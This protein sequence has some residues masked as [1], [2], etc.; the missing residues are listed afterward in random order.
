MSERT[1]RQ[2][3]EAATTHVAAAALHKAAAISAMRAEDDNSC[4]HAMETNR[5]AHRATLL[6][7]ELEDASGDTPGADNAMPASGASEEAIRFHDKHNHYLASTHHRAAAD[8]HTEAAKAWA[9]EWWNG[10]A[11]VNCDVCGRDVAETQL[12]TD[13]HD[14]VVCP[15]CHTTGMHAE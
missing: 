3:Q 6:A 2:R 7:L 14:N 5:V 8:Y 1:Q 13:K 11:F 4:R 10:V 12:M 15:D 9:K